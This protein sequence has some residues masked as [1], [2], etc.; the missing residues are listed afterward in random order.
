MEN[1]NLEK[2][3]SDGI[4][5]GKSILGIAKELGLTRAKV[6]YAYDKM[7]KQGR[8]ALAKGS[9]V[10]Y[11]R[12]YANYV[13]DEHETVE[14][15]FHAVCDPLKYDLTGGKVDTK[16]GVPINT[17]EGVER[18]TYR[19][20]SIQ[21]KPRKGGHIEHVIQYLENEF[22]PPEYELPEAKSVSDSGNGQA[23]VLGLVDY[24][25]GKLAK[26]WT[27]EEA[28]S[29]WWRVVEKLQDELSF[30]PVELIIFPIGNDFLHVDNKKGETTKGTPVLPTED[31]C[32]LYRFGELMIIRTVAVLTQLA[33]VRIV[34]VK[35]NHDWTS[36]FA[37]GR[38][39]DRYFERTER[40]DVT[41]G[42][43]EMEALVYGNNFIGF[44]HGKYRNPRDMVLK[45]AN[46][47]P[48]W[49]SCLY[50]DI[51][52]GHKHSKEEIDLN[53]A[54][55]IHLPCIADNDRWHN[56]NWYQSRRS[57][58]LRFYD[59]ELGP[60]AVIPVNLPNHQKQET[61]L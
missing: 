50:K 3:I 19:I 57:A 45:F 51:L 27:L 49:S 53:G 52:T 8:L 11:E 38:L 61:V 43:D 1:Q 22:Q 58:E 25:L 33:K 7:L 15:Y 24:H 55:V 44:T 18:V 31:W 14:D 17:A 60:N 59:R 16:E 41:M 32:K 47:Y 34:P 23:V 21:F 30:R 2:H 46:D 39:L 37:L 54:R 6:R 28:E 56:E 5:A 13:G 20:I 29:E 36:T 48:S 26:D 35:G 9:K 42:D 40:V 12:G 10:N 4:A